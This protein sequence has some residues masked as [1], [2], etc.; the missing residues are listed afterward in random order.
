MESATP[1]PGISN[2][3]LNLVAVLRQA[4]DHVGRSAAGL[5]GLGGI[6]DQVV[7]GARQLL[8][9]DPGIDRFW[10]LDRDLHLAAFGVQA[11]VLYRAFN[12]RVHRL[13]T[14]VK[15]LTCLA[16]EKQGLNEVGHALHRVPDLEKQFRALLRTGLRQAHELSIGVDGGKMMTQ[17]V[18]NRAG[19][20]ADGGQ[21]IGFQQFAV[22]AFEFAAHPVKGKRE[23]ANLR[24]AVDAQLIVKIALAQGAGAGDQHFERTSH[25]AGDGHGQRQADQQGC[26]AQ[27]HDPAIDAA[28][29]FA[30]S[31]IGLEHQ[32]LNFRLPC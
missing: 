8:A 29:V 16:E 15:Y 14:Q 32:N 24:R 26:Q 25:G 28:Q 22:T 12:Q 20:S 2:T 9:V 7:H 31:V 6:E 13:A 23:F 17:I 3:D 30:G 5:G 19:H 10:G 11:H 21:T 1:R 18:G 27:G 4:Y